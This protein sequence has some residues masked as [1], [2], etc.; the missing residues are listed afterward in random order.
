M[1]KNLKGPA[2]ELALGR[3]VVLDAEKTREGLVRV[4][5]ELEGSREGEAIRG[6]EAKRGVPALAYPLFCGDV[7]SGDRVLLNTTAVDLQLGTGGTHFVVA[8]LNRP[9]EASLAEPGHVMKL[10]YTPLQFKSLSLE[11]AYG[12][13]LGEDRGLEGMPVLVLELHSMVLPAA[14]AFKRRRPGSGLVYIMKDGGSL[15]LAFSDLADYM[16]RQGLLDAVITAGHAFGGDLEAVNVYTALLGARHILKADACIVAMGPGVLGTGTAWGFSGIEQG[17]NINRAS[18]LGGRA[19]TALRLS[20]AEGRERH[21]G[22]SHHSLT[23]LARAAL[24][25]AV[26]A[27]PGELPEEKKAAVLAQLKEAGLPGIHS[28]SWPLTGKTLED[29]KNLSWKAASMGR[30]LEEDPLFFAGAAAAGEEGARRLEPVGK[31]EP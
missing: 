10:R 30:T 24:R 4:L 11:E 22:V 3:G 28:L 21:R 26:I 27:L 18:I 5:V 7:R 8:N 2:R 31:G 13:E 23:S 16:K 25:P 17:E 15:P 14:L 20:F 1:N 19:V 9:R 6:H 29:L 12:A